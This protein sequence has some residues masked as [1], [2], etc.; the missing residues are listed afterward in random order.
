MTLSLK[1]RSALERPQP[2]ARILGDNLSVNRD[3]DWVEAAVLIAITDR[4]APGIILTQRPETMRRHAGQVAFPGGRMDP[5]DADIIAAALRE[6]EEEIALHPSQVEVIGTA[7]PYKTITDYRITPV[8]AVIPPDLLLHPNE[9]EVA[10]IFEIPLAIALDES[11]WAWERVMWE[12]QERQFYAMQF[13]KYS[14]WGAT[15]AMLI[16]LGRQLQWR[17]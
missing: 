3:A 12:G 7:A 5:D 8:V 13:E 11:R 10:A 4:P 9:E 15:A 6:A 14:I 17:T 2:T 1:L 16:N